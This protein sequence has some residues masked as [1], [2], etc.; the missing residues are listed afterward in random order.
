MAADGA[1]QARPGLQVRRLRCSHQR[2]LHSCCKIAAGAAHLSNHCKL[3][4]CRLDAQRCP[5]GSTACD[6]SHHDVSGSDRQ[7]IELPQVLGIDNRLLEVSGRQSVLT[8]TDHSPHGLRS[9]KISTY[10]RPSSSD[11]FNEPLKSVGPRGSTTVRLSHQGNV[12]PQ[13]H[14]L[15]SCMCASR[16]RRRCDEDETRTRR[17]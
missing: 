14:P 5:D 10:S 9:L 8:G 15:H 17:Q 13:Q 16:M 1:R 2:R 3:S 12:T 6:G 7:R 4:C 11:D